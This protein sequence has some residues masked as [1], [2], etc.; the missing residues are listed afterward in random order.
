MSLE[1][2]SSAAVN[3]VMAEDSVGSVWYKSLAN[4]P[5]ITVNPLFPSFLVCR[6]L[7]NM[8]FFARSFSIFI[9]ISP[10]IRAKHHTAVHHDCLHGMPRFHITSAQ[11]G[12]FVTKA[13]KRPNFGPQSN[14][15]YSSTELEIRFSALGSTFGRVVFTNPT[16]GPR[17]TVFPKRFGSIC[18]THIKYFSYEVQQRSTNSQLLPLPLHIND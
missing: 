9:L 5:S 14:E 2:V 16:F 17:D 15:N 8:Q 6:K 12:D 18:A 10:I 4:L 13:N 11:D 3:A 7:M 1:R